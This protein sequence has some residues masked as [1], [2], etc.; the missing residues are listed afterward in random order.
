MLRDEAL[1]P[2]KCSVF[3]SDLSYFFYGRPAYR[4]KGDPSL[5]DNHA[6]PVILV[7]K[8]TIENFACSAFPFDSGAFCNGRYKQW[9][10]STWE[11]DTFKI[12]VASTTHARH[13]AA[14]YEGN[15]DYLDGKGKYLHSS[16]FGFNLEAAAVSQMIRECRE[17]EADDRRFTIEMI[18]DAPIPL[19]PQYVAMV[20]VPRVLADSEELAPLVSREIHVY[21]Y[22]VITH[23][24]ASQHHAHLENAVFDRQQKEGL[25]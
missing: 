2:Q 16:N 11:I 5:L 23:L 22:R 3:K 17:G 7:F 19:D 4:F 12:D 20:I 18:A 9:L 24:T 21:P 14:F 1:N 25:L 8:N 13:V 10:D 6:W 15:E